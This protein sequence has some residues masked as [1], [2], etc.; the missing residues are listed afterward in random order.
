MPI[1]VLVVFL[2][3][4]GIDTANKT[5]HLPQNELSKSTLAPEKAAQQ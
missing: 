2:A 4:M 3:A 5:G 1:F